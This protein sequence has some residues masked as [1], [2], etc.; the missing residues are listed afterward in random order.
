MLPLHPTLGWMLP[1]M[2]GAL[3]AGPMARLV[4]LRG[5]PQELVR[6]RVGSLKTWWVITPTIAATV[7]LGQVAVAVL[8]VIVGWLALREYA[9]LIGKRTED[10]SME[11][12]AFV[13]VPL[14]YVLVCFGTSVGAAM[15][16]PLAALIVMSI[17]QTV[18]ERTDGFTKSVTGWYWALM[19]L[20]FGP[21][22]A[23]LLWTIPAEQSADVGPVGWFLFL[24]ILTE[25]NDIAQAFF[26]RRWGK[27]HI[28][29]KVSP[30]K[31]WEGLWGGVAVTTLLAVVLSPVLTPFGANAGSMPYPNGLGLTFALGAG[32]LISV[33]GYLGDINLSAVK[34][35]AGVKDSGTLL[36]GQGGILDR[37]DSLTFTAPAFYGFVLWSLS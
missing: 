32:L 8:F 22:C 13:L 25:M 10:R 28:A 18:A 1:G 3:S 36:P 21:S 5:K 33:I 17:S 37:I 16:L 7:L 26:G 19:L 6:K 20:V 30:H 27:R 24:V 35:D 14:H 34:R 15:T 12:I 4:S 29:P 11:V 31:T 9:Q 2:F 23:V